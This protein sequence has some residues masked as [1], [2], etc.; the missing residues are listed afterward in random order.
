MRLTLCPQIASVCQYR[1]N[2]I[3][4]YVHIHVLKFNLS[5]L[6]M[7]LYHKG[8]VTGGGSKSCQI[9]EGE[10]DQIC[11]WSFLIRFSWDYKMTIPLAHNNQA[12]FIFFWEEKKLSFQIYNLKITDTFV[13]VCVCSCFLLH[14][15]KYFWYK[16]L[17]YQD[18]VHTILYLDKKWGNSAMLNNK[19]Y[20]KNV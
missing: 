5:N 13:C 2:C 17:P 6:T 8:N 1:V 3:V 7:I 19:K 9:W 11:W 14:F 18:L 10:N 15:Q 12:S 20:L 4:T 16:Q